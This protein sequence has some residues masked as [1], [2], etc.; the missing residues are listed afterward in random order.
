MGEV[1]RARD[2]RLDRLVAIKV[3]QEQF[4][5]RFER[6]ARAVAALNNPHICALYDVGHNYLV[7]ELIDGKPLT[8]PLPLE[9]ALAFATQVCDAL[10]AAHRKGIVHRDLKPANILVTSTGVKLLDFGLARTTVVVGAD[11]PTNP[12]LTQAGEVM[13]TP[14]YMAPEQWEGKPGDVRTDIYAFGCVLYEMLTGKPAAQERTRVEPP[15]IEAILSACLE[16]D[17]EARWQSARDIGRALAL[18]V[19]GT[20]RSG[21][22]P[23]RSWRERAAWTAAALVALASTVVFLRFAPAR[24]TPDGARLA[25][26][27]NPPEKTTFFGAT[28]VTVQVP[29]FAL[30]PDGRALVLSA[31]MAGASRSSLWV[32]RMDEVDARLI[33]GTDD[34]QN[35]FWSPDGQWIAFFAEGK[36]KKVALSGGPVQVVLDGVPDPRGGSW[37]RDNTILIGGGSSPIARVPASGGSATV[38]TRLDPS[39]NEASHRWPVWLPDGLHFL[40]TVRSGS[41]ENSGLYLTT[42]GGAPRRLVPGRDGSVAYAAPGY[43][44]F[45]EGDTLFAQQLDASRFELSGQ[46]TPIADRVGNSS[47]GFGSFAVS[48]TGILGYAPTLSRTGRLTWFDRSGTPTGVLGPDG[49]YGDIQLSPDGKRVAYSLMDP[50]KGVPDIWLADLASERRSRFTFGPR[51]NSGP[52]WSPDGTRIVFR[53]T[54]KGGQLEFYE[55]SSASGGNETPVLLEETQRAVDGRSQNIVASDWSPDARYILYSLSTTARTDLWLLPLMDAKK[56]RE[57]LVTQSDNLHGSFSP[58]DGRLVVYSSNETGR[59][60]VYVQTFP[61]SDRKWTVS[62]TGGYEPRWRADGREIFYLSEDRKLMAVSVGPGPTFGVPSV[63]FQTRVPVE[64]VTPYRTHYAANRDGSRF[65]ITTPSGETPPTPI[66]LLVNWTS[67]LQKQG[68][69]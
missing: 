8:G 64:R 1:Y 49:D 39:R 29:H 66:T 55:K 45:L 52:V 9:Q 46:P 35:P 56:P 65:L 63:L 62:T 48:Q 7:M 47:N 68:G 50:K 24:N 2:T 11:S 41:I 58:P 31:A 25:L 3:S 16:R 19:G 60:E 14:G 26:S 40:F 51:L 21:P 57:F 17:P 15:A 37:G 43:L 34:A 30:A 38:V 42:L 23:A 69:P 59:F 5:E 10:D 32:R 28:N 13:G 67:G 27:L 61:L 44:L 18:P 36:L 53:T 22:P 12:K 6:E 4:S 54:R 20:V 33:P